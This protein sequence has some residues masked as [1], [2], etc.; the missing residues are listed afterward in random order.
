[1]SW[2]AA[3]RFN[4]VMPN[5]ANLSIICLGRINA[6]QKVEIDAFIAIYASQGKLASCTQNI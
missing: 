4:R 2:K 6:E 5:L 1:M 3:K